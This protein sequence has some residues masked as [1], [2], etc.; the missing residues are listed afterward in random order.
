[1][2]E[3]RCTLSWSSWKPYFA[4]NP[5]CTIEDPRPRICGGNGRE[6]TSATGSV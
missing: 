5:I 4:N 2:V 3:V 1:M 6:E